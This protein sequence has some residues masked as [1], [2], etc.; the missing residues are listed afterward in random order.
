MEARV[1]PCYF[2]PCNDSQD[3]PGQGI[4]LLVDNT[5]AGTQVVHKTVTIVGIV[6]VFGMELAN[7][8]DKIVGEELAVSVEGYSCEPVS[9]LV[10]AFEIVVAGATGLRRVLELH[11]CARQ[12]N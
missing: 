2:L 5:T 12:L 8:E 1:L 7:F 10:V 6:V 3:M 4:H 11:V 9:L